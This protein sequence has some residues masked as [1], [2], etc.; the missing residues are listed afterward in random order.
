MTDQRVLVVDDEESIRYTFEDFLSHDGYQ[1]DLAHDYDSAIERFRQ[2]EFDLVF[3]DILLIGRSGIEVLRA[4]RNMNSRAQIIMITGA[5]S[6]KSA[7]EA[8][9]LGALDYIVKPV[10]QESLLKTARMAMRHKRMTEEKES[11]QRNVECI[12]KSVKDGIVTVTQD[13][14]VSAINDAALRICGL[15]GNHLV[16]SPVQEVFGPCNMGCVRALLDTLAHRQSVE[17]HH[18][19][20][21]AAHRTRQIVS[22][23]AAPLLDHQQKFSGGVMVI[24]DES[25]LF[26]LEQDLKEQREL[27]RIVGNNAALRRVKDLIKD[28]ADVNTTVLISGES[29]TG[30][31][32]VV[33]AIHEIS[34]RRNRPLVKVNCSAL[35]EHLLE[36]ELFGHVKGAFTGAVG[37]QTGRFERADGGTIFLDE[38]GD[39]TPRMQLRLLRVIET[40]TLERVGDGTPIRIDVRIIAATHQDL[41]RRVEEREFRED[42][43]YRLKVVEVPLP[44]LR[45]RRDDIPL[46]VAHFVRRFNAKFEKQIKAVSADALALLMGHDWP[47]NVRE[48]ENALE[49]AFVLCHQATITIDH[50]PPEFRSSIPLSLPSTLTAN[51]DN[52]I[53]R[54]VKILRKTDGNKAKAARLLGMSRKTIYRKIE[55]YGLDA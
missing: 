21:R 25:R 33:D 4:I 38:I 11:C 44:P 54:I 2:K 23:S 5:P 3:V 12:F 40:M 43:F 28:L 49:H 20:C 8:M 41:R 22:I 50:L 42:L 53:D 18:V 6:V 14:S 48:L 15:S 10:D 1:V 29:G 27:N 24:R 30:K 39:I 35:S 47:G 16:G 7:S 34:R 19:E 52:E 26:E 36:S 37:D 31:E 51:G 13:M 45:E 17:L 32:L 55:K 46:L 9:R